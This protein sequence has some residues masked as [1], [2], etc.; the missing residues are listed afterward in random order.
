[1]Y[2]VIFQTDSRDFY[3]LTA[4]SVSDF[5]S[6]T[7]VELLKWAKL[8]E[9]YHL[10]TSEEASTYKSENDKV[11][12]FVNEYIK[13]HLKWSFTQ[14]DIFIDSMVTRELPNI[15]RS[16]KIIVT[17]PIQFVIILILNSKG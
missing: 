16:Y 6:E 12:A 5:I 7:D 9:G 4:V 13:Q 14:K 1:M 10:I 8:F 17:R 11:V 2:R 15:G 3:E